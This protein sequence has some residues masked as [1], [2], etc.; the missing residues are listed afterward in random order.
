MTTNLFHQ[1]ELLN[2]KQAYL[3]D[4][5]ESL[6]QTFWIELFERQI[7]TTRGYFGADC[8]DMMIMN[9]SKANVSHHSTSLSLSRSGQSG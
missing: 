2:I 9:L 1:L 3:S 5:H 8:Y 7:E 6:K 4:K